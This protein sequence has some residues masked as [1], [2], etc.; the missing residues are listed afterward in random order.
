VEISDDIQDSLE[1]ANVQ[2]WTKLTV[3]E[4]HGQKFILGRDFYAYLERHFRSVTRF[5]PSLEAATSIG[6][7]PVET[8]FFLEK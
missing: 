4:Y 5:R 8:L 2:E 1:I 6:A 3:R 7:S